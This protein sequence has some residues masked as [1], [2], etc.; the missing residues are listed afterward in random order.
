MFCLYYRLQMFQLL[1]LH[2]LEKSK[3]IFNIMLR[4]VICTLL[5]YVHLTTPLGIIIFSLTFK[6][7]FFLF[8]FYSYTK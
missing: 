6:N 7:V 2:T 3:A 1:A 4:S 8:L 5:D